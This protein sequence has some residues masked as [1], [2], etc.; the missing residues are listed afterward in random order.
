MKPLILVLLT[1][2]AAQAQSLADV[3]RKERA[4]QAQVTSSRT[5]TNDHVKGAVPAPAPTPSAPADASKPADEAKPESPPSPPA[6][7]QPSAQ[8]NAAA[9]NAIQEWTAQYDKTRARIRELQDQET[10]LQLQAN[11]LTNRFYAPVTD[12]AARTQAQVSL[13]EVQNKLIDVRR[14]LAQQRLALQ[15]LEA[16][17][18]KK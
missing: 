4:R 10:A 8:P 15:R 5:V 6:A 1:A 2:I 16:Q 18:P 14:E 12:Q 3:A 9:V 17:A 11:D 7:V 13:M